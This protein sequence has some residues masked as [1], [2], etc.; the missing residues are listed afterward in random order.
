AD[1]VAPL[2]K[3]RGAGDVGQGGGCF[4]LARR[5]ELHLHLGGRARHGLGALGGE[6]AAAVGGHSTTSLIMG[7]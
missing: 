6:E 5:L 3:Q 2:R 7:A 1:H 4:A